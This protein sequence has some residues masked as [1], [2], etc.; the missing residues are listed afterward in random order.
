M[1]LEYVNIRTNLR[2]QQLCVH[3]VSNAVN[4]SNARCLVWLGWW[5]YCLIALTSIILIFD[6]LLPWLGRKTYY[7]KENCRYSNWIACPTLIYDNDMFAATKTNDGTQLN[8]FSK[9]I[10]TSRCKTTLNWQELAYIG[11]VNK[12]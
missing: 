1:N 11:D 5:I 8:F 3:T 9:R 6:F 7:K 12:R 10:M 2:F 4:G